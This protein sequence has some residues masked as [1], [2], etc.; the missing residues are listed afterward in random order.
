M[1][2]V[3]MSK[4]EVIE[5]NCFKIDP[6]I[7]LHGSTHAT[8][9][10]GQTIQ[11]SSMALGYEV[12]YDEFKGTI[13]VAR[14]YAFSEL[15]LFAADLLVI[16]SS[17]REKGWRAFKHLFSEDGRCLGMN[18]RFAPPHSLPLFA[19]FMILDSPSADE[20]PCLD[21]RGYISEKQESALIK[22][23]KGV[24]KELGD[25]LDMITKFSDKHMTTYKREEPEK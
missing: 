15:K 22:A 2:I 16:D 12:P 9:V 7:Y 18:V 10:S 14:R 24:S 11:T 13:S 5:T 17:Y 21:I 1:E 3:Y 4:Q 8:L 19:D 6:H 20:S 23:L 25:S